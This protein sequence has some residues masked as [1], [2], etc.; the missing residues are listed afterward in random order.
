V[1]LFY[2]RARLYTLAFR[3][4]AT[5]IFL[6]STRSACCSCQRLTNKQTI[7]H[8]Q[9]LK[10]TINANLYLP[11]QPHKTG[12]LSL[13]LQFAPALLSDWRAALVMGCDSTA[14]RMPLIALRTPLRINDCCCKRGFEEST[15][16]KHKKL[17]KQKTR[18]RN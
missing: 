17:L 15:S 12:R 9:S 2:R 16:Q 4:L 10:Q 1:V 8:N 5:Q 18:T 14:A 3:L 6:L 11:A 13:P 7:N